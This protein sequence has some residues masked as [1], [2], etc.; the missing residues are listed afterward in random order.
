ME[1]AAKK[2]RERYEQ[3]IERVQ[4]KYGELYKHFQEQELE[5][6]GEK[7]KLILHLDDV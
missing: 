2:E 4:K 1:N 3:E 7:Q 6:R 5:L